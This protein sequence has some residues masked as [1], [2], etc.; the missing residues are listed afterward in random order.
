MSG[1]ANFAFH[2]H[3]L[4]LVM[5]LEALCRIAVKRW[6]REG[7]VAFYCPLVSLGSGE[8]N[9][10]ASLPDSREKP[11]LQALNISPL[12]HKNIGRSGVEW[13]HGLLGSWKLEAGSWRS[14]AMASLSSPARNF[15]NNGWCLAAGDNLQG[16]LLE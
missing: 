2:S 4:N 12:P 13:S 7:D 11:P 3:R 5:G 15:R 16:L 9:P 14:L 10:A 6:E 1:K 8:W